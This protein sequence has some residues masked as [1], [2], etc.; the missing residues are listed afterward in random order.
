MWCGIGVVWVLGLSGLVGG[1]A[2]G[3]S[4]W[5]H[6]LRN[7]LH[8]PFDER[9]IPGVQLVLWDLEIGKENAHCFY[10]MYIWCF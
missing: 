6:E 3:I 1:W 10:G 5:F 8:K 4:L 9:D 2:T 7:N